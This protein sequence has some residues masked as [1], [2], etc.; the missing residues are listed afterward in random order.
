MTAP[1][2]N[3]AALSRR[4]GVARDTLRKWELRYAVLQ[5]ERTA[6][7][8]RRY[9]E[10]DVQRVEWL[11]DRIA[12]G[13]RIGEAARLLDV[14]GAGPPPPGDAAAL[15]E[16]LVKA[17]RDNDPRSLSA[18]LDQT[19]AV[20]PPERALG[21]VVA[22]VLAWVGE[23]WHAG[24]ASIAQ[25][26]L[27]SAKV[28]AHL[29][30]LLSEGRGEVRGSAVL[31]CAPGELHEIGLMML[32]VALRADGWRVEY[33]GSDTPVES[34]LSFARATD[35]VIACISVTRVESLTNVRTSLSADDVPAGTTLVLGGS[36][37]TPEIA[38]ELGAVYAEEDLGRA[39]GRLRSLA[40]A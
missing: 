36:A 2:L 39:V 10:G 17:I 31:A 37:I 40:T 13:W 27:V 33:L 8:Q 29:G 19:F 34:T 3:I 28:K 11:R 30:G 15:R 9:S 4:T 21:E 5:P 14:A 32:A 26:H 24:E 25:E 35:A 12:E 38:A 16:A 7:G 20:L 23:A 22:P 1:L 6:G 18:L